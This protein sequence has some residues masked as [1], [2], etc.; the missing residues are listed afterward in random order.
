MSK[1]PL[2]LIVEDITVNSQ[3]IKW[4]IS[5][6]YDSLCVESGEECLEII[7]NGPLPDLILLDVTMPG[8]GG[9]ETCRRLKKNEKSIDIPIIF[10]TALTEGGDEKL[11][12][13]LGAV[14]YIA[15]PVNPA[16]VKARIH[17][18]ITMKLQRDQLNH[19]AFHDQL[20]GL[21][22]RYYLLETAED[23]VSEVLR[24]KSGLWLLMIDIDN[25]KKI[26]DMHGHAIGDLI[27]Q[28]VAHT[29]Q[30]EL[31][32]HDLV[33]RFGGEEFIILFSPCNKKDALIKSKKLIKQ[34]EALKPNDITVTI[35]IGLSK[36]LLDNNDNLT[37]LLKR[38]DDAL[39]IAKENGRNRVEIR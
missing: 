26:N 18:H 7:K 9:H 39:Y 1:K 2:V 36:L 29:L 3:I 16:I 6:E 38:A 21:Y 14:D 30:S 32:S 27:L 31:R 5:S 4:C 22:N 23:K 28:K 34:I 24:S 8:I 20:T 25:F 33:S 35:S 15:K 11:G 10:I 19:I 12:F 13:D 37:S 17:T